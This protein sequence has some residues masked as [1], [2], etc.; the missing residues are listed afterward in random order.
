MRRDKDRTKT[1]EDRIVEPCPRALQALKRQLEPIRNLNDPLAPDLSPDVNEHG[2]VPAI[3]WST[4]PEG[5][6][7]P[8][9]ESSR[10][11]G[12]S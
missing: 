10:L 11:T 4:T 9:A 2:V 5:S 12:Y 1:S 6:G 7:V 3:G 8:G